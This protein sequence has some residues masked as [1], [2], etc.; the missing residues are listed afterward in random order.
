MRKNRWNSLYQLQCKKWKSLIIIKLVQVICMD[1]S[2]LVMS[3]KVMV[4]IWIQRL[5]VPQTLYIAETII[6][7]L[8]SVASFSIKHKTN[9]Y[10][11]LWM[12]IK[13]GGMNGIGVVGDSIPVL[14]GKYTDLLELYVELFLFYFITFSSLIQTQNVTK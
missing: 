5:A 4:K 7:L 14:L 2:I 12:N 8:N 6:S 1:V 3:I 13:Y 11:C 10:K 9:W